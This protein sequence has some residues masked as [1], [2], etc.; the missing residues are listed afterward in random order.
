MAFDAGMVTAVADELRRSFI[1]ARVEKVQ[2]PEK[3]ELILV[4]HRDRVSE[5]LLISASP[6]SPRIHITS[7]VKENPLTAPMFCMLLR[8]HLSGAKLTEIIQPGFERVLEFVFDGTDEMGF[9]S[10]S[11]LIVEIM[12]KYSNIIFCGADR[13]I[14][15]ACRNVDFTT[16][17]KRQVLPGMKY[18]LPPPQEKLDPRTESREHFLS[19]CRAEGLFDGGTLRADKFITA[20]YLGISALLAKE[21]AYR[22]QESCERLYDVMSG[23]FRDLGNG[24]YLPTL[25]RD[26]DK[27][28]IEYCFTDIGVYGD[29]AF[30]E[31]PSGISVM[32]ESFFGERD[33]AERRRQRESDILHMLG[34]A[35]AR[36]HRKL[37]LQ[38]EELAGCTDGGKMKHFGDLITSNIWA[39]SKGMSSVE[40]TDYY[41]EQLE[42]VT[43]PLDP[44]MSPSQNAQKY[45]KK[46][47]KLKTAERVLAEQIAL[48]ESELAYIDTV[49]DALSRCE[50]ES[51]IDEIRT[52]LAETGFLKE[53]KSKKSQKKQ[54]RR[55]RAIEYRT[56]GGYR[57]LC[58]RNN[59]QN[60]ILTTKT[61]E[62]SDWWFHAKN[63][64]GS[65]VVMFTDGESEPDASDF[66]E[67]AEIAAFNSKAENGENTAVDYTQV[68]YIKKPA[69]SRPG[70]VTYTKNWTAYVTPDPDR[71]SALRVR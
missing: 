49:L 25:I 16:S 26:A 5:R 14:L 13:R 41:S 9:S 19:L 51:D 15:G 23:I 60:D 32:L 56:S 17:Q 43:V 58:G 1:G 37:A 8:K 11:L 61:A 69:G 44:R 52:E 59:I 42:Q 27:K 48:A 20:H 39:I 71:I 70:F 34:N 7:S 62:R 30:A 54:L 55:A 24:M 57:V 3:D 6:S 18:E 33:R 45:Y 29:T 36:L 35:D 21:I 47:S 65:H 66:T 31:H 28:P 4:L 50:S 67:A 53:L 64:P 2:Q 68:K 40:L 38:R 12:G 46:Y 22:A 10:E 63:V